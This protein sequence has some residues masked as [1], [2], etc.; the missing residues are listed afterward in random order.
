VV[1]NGALPQNT[2]VFLGSDEMNR[3]FKDRIYQ[4]CAEIGVEFEGWEFSAG[5]FKNKSLKHSDLFILPGFGFKDENTPLQPAV[6]ILNKKASVLS[7]NIVGYE[8]STS[9]INF[10]VIANELQY[11][12]ERLRVSAAIF[13]D[14]NLYLEAVRAPG[15]YDDQMVKALEETALDLSEARSVLRAMMEDAISLFERFYDLSSEE[16]L[17][18]NLPPKYKTRHANSP[19][20][21]MEKQKGVMICLVHLLLGDFDFVLNYRSDD[22]K[23]IFPKRKK[24][25]DDIIASL[26]EL[27]RRY[28]ETGSVI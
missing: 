19:Y 23:T 28:A 27:K 6:S 1:T 22:Y 4:M 26:P 10:Q 16:N 17:L 2:S 8:L 5:K 9:L 12:P 14:K 3:I 11:M 21:E 15:A 13:Q 25:L 18:K 20:D 7:K 24:E